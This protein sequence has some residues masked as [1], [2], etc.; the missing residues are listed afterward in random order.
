MNEILH[1]DKSQCQT[2]PNQL[3][4]VHI[5]VCN[6]KICFHNILYCSSAAVC[7]NIQYILTTST[8]HFSTVFGLK[9]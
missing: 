5:S 3:H 6:F 1:P 4:D 7:P 2:D 8:N 9:K